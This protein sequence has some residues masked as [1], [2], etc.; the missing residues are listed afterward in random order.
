MLASLHAAAAA[1]MALVARWQTGRGQHVDISMQEAVASITHLF[2]AAK[3]L[4]DGILVTR[5]QQSNIGGAPTGYHPCKDGLI[6]LSVGRAWMWPILARWMA[7]VTGNQAI[8][9]LRFEGPSINR[10]QYADLI[11]LWVD[12]FT[13]LFTKD[14]FYHE[15]QKRKLAVAPISA[16]ADLL[17]NQQLAA[18]GFWVEVEHPAT[19]KLRYPGAPYKLSPTTWAIRRPA[20]RP[21]EHNKEV[22]CEELGVS[23][24]RLLELAR[25]GVV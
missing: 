13:M 8:L 19:G 25:A 7:E 10:V 6:S 3:Y 23:R 17:G 11:N 20:P 9:D 15:A 12:E 22:L 14:E 2:G 1:T 24:R 5:E 18:R 4:D 16:P 21:G